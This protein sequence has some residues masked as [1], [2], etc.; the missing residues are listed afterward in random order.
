MERLL[1]DEYG[2]VLGDKVYLK[3]YLD[4][5]D[6]EIGEVRRTPEEAV[7]Y[8]KNRFS[9]AE[10]KVVQLFQQVE[11][12]QNKGSYLT[13]LLQLRKTLAEF[14][15]WGN[16]APF[17]VQLDK[18]EV[19]LRDLIVVNQK[20]NL[21]IKRA[22]LE[23][24]R[25]AAN[26]TDW[27]EATEALQELK[28][29]WLK[30]GPVE[31]PLDDEV[32]AEFQALADSFF[33]KRREFFAEKNRIIDEKIARYEVLVQ[34]A[35]ELVRA[36][37]LDDAFQKMRQLQNE[38]KVIGA[39]PPKKQKMMWRDFKYANNGFFY[40]YN[41]A[42]GIVQQPRVNPILDALKRMAE[43]ATKLP[44][45]DD[46]IKASERAKELLNEWK[47]TSAKLK[48]VDRD[49]SEKFRLACDKVFEMNYLMRV[50]SYRYPDFRDKPRR[51]QLKI[52]IHQMDYLV[53]KEKNDLETYTSNGD[54][55]N[56]NT[57]MDRVI[58]T[59]ITTQKRKVAVKEMIL[60]ELREVLNNL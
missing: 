16:F 30:T 19:Y 57:E 21:E 8:F 20:K 11:E 60:T 41:K 3:S 38:W 31:K 22:L 17:F 14:D 2:Y 35:K 45:S 32:E 43:E 23:E 6:R 25:A 39:I 54:S 36:E 28:L 12:A 48:V 34:T 15:G 42:K 13:K 44:Y 33:Q 1:E 40:R 53:K 5:P 52:Q 46:M 49:L 47:N 4:F 7:Q 9:I 59:K 18:L 50:I 29:K 10:T 24:T 56:R 55:F 37:D 26:R 51:D 58:L 27:A